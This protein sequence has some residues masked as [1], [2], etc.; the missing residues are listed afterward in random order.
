M[1]QDSFK[2]LQGQIIALTYA[3]DLA[4]KHHPME[5]IVS[6]EINGKL[7]ALSSSMLEQ[8]IKDSADG[9]ERIRLAL[10][11]GGGVGFS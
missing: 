4:I 11:S 5:R 9:V 10:Q 3:L 8:G 7:D 2:F 1:Q 6:V